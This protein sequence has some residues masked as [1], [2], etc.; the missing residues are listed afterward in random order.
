MSIF[1]FGNTYWLNL[2]IISF[3]PFEGVIYPQ[4]DPDAVSISKTDVERLQPKTFIND[5]IIDFYIK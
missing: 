3:E 1:R 5:T 2:K 4:G